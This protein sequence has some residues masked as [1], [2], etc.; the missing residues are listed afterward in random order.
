MQV[1]ILL[2]THLKEPEEDFNFVTDVNLKG[3]FFCV[4]AY[5][6]VLNKTHQEK[7]NIINTASHYG[8]ISP[9]FRIY[10]DCDRRNS[11][12]YGAN[13]SWHHTNVQKYFDS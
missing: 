12:V 7:G 13:K 3:T 2:N 10:T 6:E 8:T 11:E 1:S 9:D 5:R 4:Q